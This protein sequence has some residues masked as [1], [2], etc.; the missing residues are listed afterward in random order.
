YRGRAAEQVHLGEE[1]LEA[2]NLD[3]VG[4]A[5]EADVPTRARRPDRLHHRLLGTDRLDHR[6]RAESVRQLLDAGDTIVAALVHDVRRAELA[7][8]LLSLWI[9]T[10]EN[11]AL[12]AHLPGGNHCAEPNGPV[13]NDDNRLAWRDGGRVST[14]PPGPEH[15]GCRQKAR[16]QLVRWELR[17]GDECAVRQRHPQVGRL[18]TFRAD[19]LGVHAT[20]LIACHADGTYVVG[21]EEGAHDE[22]AALDLFHV[23]ADF[24]DDAAVLV[25]HRRWPVRRVYAP[26][27]PEIGAADTGRRHA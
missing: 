16:H 5:D 11:D 20:A 6:V 24:L 27:G 4:D 14:E 1:Q 18:G 21:R 17:C 7:T 26:V 3:A 15:V 22:L 12:G 2:G 13:A 9:A 25:A 8:E 10:H 23:A 19:G